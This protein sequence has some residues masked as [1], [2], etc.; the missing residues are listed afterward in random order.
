MEESF[1]VLVEENILQPKQ[2]PERFLVIF[3]DSYT[4]NIGCI[5]L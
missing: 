3:Q 4:F 2:N 1:Q 5:N